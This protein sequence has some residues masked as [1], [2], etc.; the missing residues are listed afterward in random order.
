MD[1]AVVISKAYGMSPFDILKQD[2]DSVIMLINYFIDKADMEE[3]VAPEE[4][5]EVRED[6]RGGVVYRRVTNS[7]ATGGWF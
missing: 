3:E 1:F 7:T 5:P 2:K 6:I 4:P